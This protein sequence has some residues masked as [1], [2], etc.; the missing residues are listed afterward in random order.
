MFM[1]DCLAESPISE[2]IRGHTTKAIY[3][4]EANFIRDD[5]DLYTSLLFTLNTTN[6]YLIAESTP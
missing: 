3:L 2:T 1:P 5:A 6:G 4:M